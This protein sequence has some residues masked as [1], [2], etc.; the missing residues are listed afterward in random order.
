MYKNAS[1]YVTMSNMKLNALKNDQRGIVDVW[2][3]AFLGMLVLFFGATGFGVWA[4]MGKQDYK[5]N[6][7][8]K[9]AAAVAKADEATT[10][11]KDAE[12][13]EKEKQPLRIYTGPQAF[14]SVTISYPKTWSVYMDESSRSGTPL[15]G[16]FNPGFVPGLT[17]DNNVALRIEVLNTAYSEVASTMESSVKNGKVTARAI[18][19]TKVPSAIGLRLDGEVVSKKQGAMVILPLRDKTLKIW[20]EATQYV[21]DFD[22]IILPNLTFSP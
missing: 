10:A 11:K 9:I 20:T 17:S 12:F 19:A 2:F 15:S 3:L 5:N 7:D 16:S 18:T 1:D 21:G 22:N 13:V 8:P 14:G 6:V 4:F